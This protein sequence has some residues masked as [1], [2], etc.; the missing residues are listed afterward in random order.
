MRKAIVL[1]SFGSTNIEGLKN[2]IHLL[3]KDIKESFDDTTVISV[4]SSNKIITIL[5]ERYN[6]YVK[7]LNKCLF[8]LAS[9]QYE[10]VIIQ[11]LNIMEEALNKDIE[12]IIDEYRYS[13][14]RIVMA[15]SILSGSGE[16]LKERCSILAE[17]IL[18]KSSKL[19]ILLIGHGSKTNPNHCYDVLRS[20]FQQKSGRN[21]FMATLE[22]NITLTNVIDEMKKDDIKDIVLQ[23]LFLIKGKHLMNDIFGCED[24]WINILER[25]GFNV[26]AKEKALLQ[27]KTVRN[28]YVNDLKSLL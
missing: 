9:D 1:V 7:K 16:V 27:Y 19:P 13:F 18:D 20:V 4:F 17:S 25:E 5:K 8:D 3:E 11:P 23:P 12:N 15:K 24:S 21:T 22:G 6:I 28:I 10:E 2:T 14:K 26:I